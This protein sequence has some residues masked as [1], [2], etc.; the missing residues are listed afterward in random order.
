MSQIIENALAANLAEWI[1]ANLP[2]TTPDYGE[3]LVAN[4][5][6]IRTRPCIVLATA[7]PKPVSPLKHT[8]R[9]RL[10]VHLFTQI[11]DTPVADHNAIASAIEGLLADTAGIRADLNSDTFV[12]HALLRRDSGTAPDETRGRE[13]TLTYEAVVSAL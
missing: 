2:E 1:T 8:E 6:A 7:D 4:R 5:D 13:T 11:D 3:V 9:I 12:L 10:E